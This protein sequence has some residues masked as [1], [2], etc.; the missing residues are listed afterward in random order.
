[1]KILDTINYYLST[2][3]HLLAHIEHVLLIKIVL[4]LGFAVYCCL[5]SFYENRLKIRHKA[6]ISATLSGLKS[7]A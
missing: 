7:Q 1:M 3:P 4:L 5:L 2:H 6:E